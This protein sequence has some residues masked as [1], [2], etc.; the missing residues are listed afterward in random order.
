M[1]KKRLGSLSMRH[2]GLLLAMA[3]LTIAYANFAD[4]PSLMAAVTTCELPVYNV[5]TEEKVLSVSFDAAWGR[6]NT[7]GILDILD[8][9]GVKANF[10]LVGFWAEKYPEL[11]AELQARGHEVGNHS[12]THPHM[13]KLSDAQIREELK[14]CSDLV[15]SVTGKPTTLFRPPYGEYNDEVVRISREEGYECIQWNVDSLDW[16]NISAEDMVRRCTK[17]VNPGDIVLFHND[18]K[19]ILQALPQILE[20]YQ[21]AGYRIIPISEL[22]LEGDTWI[23]HAGTQ[24]LAT[25]APSAAE[26]ETD[27]ESKKIEQ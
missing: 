20:Y 11:V 12:A 9:Y 7:E 15:Q 8:Q 14:R 6:A 5:D 18:S 19:Y 24:H 1:N 2:W 27:I 25:P 26:K 10:F 4:S 16:K 17:A 13:S 21:Q 23:D 22:L 3:V